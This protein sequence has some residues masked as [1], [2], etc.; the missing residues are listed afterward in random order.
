MPRNLNRRYVKD[1][2]FDLWAVK[3]KAKWAF[4]KPNN[5]A[6]LRPLIL[7]SPIVSGTERVK[8]PTQKPDLNGKNH[9][10]PHKP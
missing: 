6:Y 4:N 10:Y 1:T 3:K 2:E 5:E 9:F 8:H 7:K